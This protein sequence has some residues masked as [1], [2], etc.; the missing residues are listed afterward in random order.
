MI[1]LH[2][3]QVACEE[4]GVFVLSALASGEALGEEPTE[5]RQLLGEDE[6]HRSHLVFHEDL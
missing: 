3:F 6:A 5:V 1:I 4:R 2:G